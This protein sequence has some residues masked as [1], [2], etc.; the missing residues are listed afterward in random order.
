M[1]K[2]EILLGTWNDNPLR[3]VVLKED[4]F[5]MLVICEESIGTRQFNGDNSTNTWS[6]SDLRKFLNGEFFETA[7][8]KEDK[9]KIVNSYLEYPEGT[10]DNIFILSQEEMKELLLKDGIDEYENTYYGSFIFNKCKCCCWTR[11][12]IAN[13]IIIGFA[14]GCWCNTNIENYY[15]VRPA[16][17]IKK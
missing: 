3:W 4:D 12:K 15:N 10:K 14:K 5:S 6:D 13:A 2:K 9:K 1:A 17:Y 8:L 11:T 7:F 16:M